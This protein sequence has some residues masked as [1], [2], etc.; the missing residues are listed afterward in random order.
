MYSK[1][2]WL[3]ED[4][5]INLVKSCD[6]IIGFY[7]L[8]D[9]IGNVEHEVANNSKIIALCHEEGANFPSMRKARLNINFRRD[10]KAS[11]LL[12][13]GEALKD[14]EMFYLKTRDLSFFNFKV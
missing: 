4:D 12:E 1:S 5:T 6:G 3:V 7:T 13:I 11:L 9:S 10:E 8:N 14:A 2:Q